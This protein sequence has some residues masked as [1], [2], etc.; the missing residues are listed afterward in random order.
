VVIKAHTDS[1]GDENYNLL[2]SMRRAKS[3]KEALT[4]RGVDESRIKIAWVGS[5]ELLVDCGSK[6]C[7]QAD[8]ALNRRAEI[9]VISESS[10][11]QVEGE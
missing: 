3:L 9:V 4:Q 5:S 1:R 2:L 8:H 7:S 10:R 11:A 6:P